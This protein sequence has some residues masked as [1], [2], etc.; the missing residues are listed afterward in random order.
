M[1]KTLIF[2]ILFTVGLMAYGQNI[3]YVNENAAGNGSGDSWANAYTDLADALKAAKDNETQWSSDNPLQIWIAEGTYKPK[4]HPTTFEVNATDRNNTFLL[5][6][7]VNLY[8]GFDGT[9]TSLAERNWNSHKTILSGDIGAV[10]NEADNCYHVLISTSTTDATIIDGLYVTGGIGDVETSFDLDGKSIVNNHGAGFLCLAPITINNCDF[11]SNAVTGSEADGGGVCLVEGPVNMTNCRFRGNAAQD[12]GGGFYLMKDV[13][14]YA[15]NCLFSGNKAEDHGGAI[16]NDGNGTFINCT[17]AENKAKDGGIMDVVFTKPILTN[18]IGIGNSDGIVGDLSADVTYSLMQGFAANADNHNIDASGVS[19][20]DIFVNPIGDLNSV[21]SVEGDYHSLEGSVVI[22]AG[23]NSAYDEAKGG[24]VDMENHLRILNSTIDLGVYELGMSASASGVLYVSNN[25]SGEQTGESW[26]NALA[27]VSDALKYAY[28][29]ASLYSADNPLQIWVAEGTYMPEYNPNNFAK[30]AGDRDNA[31]RLVSNVHIYGGFAGTETE[32][33][34]RDWIA[35]K[36]ILSGD[37]GVRGNA[38]D[39]CYHVL[40][41]HNVTNCVFNGLVL[42]DGQADGS[43]GFSIDAKYYQRDKGGLMFIRENTLEFVNCVIKNNFSKAG[44]GA[45]SGEGYDITAVNSLFYE[46]VV[47]SGHGGVIDNTAGNF[48]A[49]NCTFSKNSADA[50]AAIKNAMAANSYLTNCIVLGNNNGI[51]NVGGNSS[52]SYSLVQGLSSTENGNIDATGVVPTDVFVDY[53]AYDFSLKKTSGLIN[54]GSSAAY[55]TDTYGD[56]DLTGAS[57]VYFYDID[58][59]AYECQDMV[60]IPSADNVLFVKENGTGNGSSWDKAADLAD[61]LKYAHEFSASWTSAEPLN[62]WVAEGKYVPKY[63]PE[64]FEMNASNRDNSF[65]LVSN[66]HIF[67]GF[68]GTETSVAERNWNSYKTVLSGDIGA[69]GDRSDNCYHVLVGIKA[70]NVIFNGLTFSDGQ[71]NGGGSCAIGGEDAERYKGGFIENIRSTFSLINCIVK[72]NKSSADAGAIHNVYGDITAVN[73]LF[74]GNEVLAG[75]NDGGAIDNVGDLDMINCTFVNNKAAQ[76]GSAIKNFNASSCN[77]TNCI[78]IGNKDGIANNNSSPNIRYSLVQGLTST[79]NGNIDASG[80][81]P[82][83]VFADYAAN[84]FSLATGWAGINVG[85]VS[86]YNSSAYGNFDLSCNTR[87]YDGGIDLGAYEVQH[88]GIEITGNILY[89]DAA[90]TGNG[91]GNSWENACTSLAYALKQVYLHRNDWNAT[92][93]LQIWVA[94]GTYKPEY[95]LR[96]ENVFVNAGRENV[97]VLVDNVNLYG[98][99]AGTE[100][101]VE[102][103]D[104]TANKT[105]LSGNVGLA[106]EETDNCYHVAVASGVAH[107]IVVD[108]FTFSHGKADF[109]EVYSIN[110]NEVKGNAGAGLYVVDSKLS[111]RNCV[112]EDNHASLGG[113]VY[114]T[115]SSLTVANGIFKANSSTFNGGTFYN[116]SAFLFIYNTLLA[117]NAIDNNFNAQGAGIYNELSTKS[118]VVVTNCTFVGNEGYTNGCDIYNGAERPV[119]VGNTIA[120]TNDDQI[121]AFSGNVSV[122]YSLVQ[123]LEADD[124]NHN[125]DGTNLIVDS[126]FADYGMEDYTLNVNGLAVNSGSNNLFTATNGENKDLLANTRISGCAI[127]LGAYEYQ[128]D[129]GGLFISREFQNASVEANN[130]S[131]EVTVV[132]GSGNFSYIWSPKPSESNGIDNLD[133]GTYTCLIRDNEYGCVD[134][135]V[136]VIEK[137]GDNAT[138]LHF[139]GDDDHIDLGTS[140][141]KI[142]YDNNRVTVEA[143]VKPTTS[144]GRFGVIAGNYFTAGIQEV[145]FCLRRENSDY[146]FFNSLNESVRINN[147]VKLNEWQHVVGVFDGDN[148]L[149]YVD[150]ESATKSAANKQLNRVPN[151]PIWIGGNSLNFGEVSGAEMFQ[152]WID[153]VRI[154]KTARTEAE[155]NAN[156]DIDLV[157]PTLQ[158]DLL[159]YYKFNQG[160]AN[161]DNP[162]ENVLIDFSQN[163]IRGSLNNFSLSGEESNWTNNSIFIEVSTEIADVQCAGGS[164]GQ[165]HATITGGRAPYTCSWTNSVSTE[166]DLTDLPANDYVLTVTDA[167]NKTLSKTIHVN[168]GSSVVPAPILQDTLVNYTYGDEDVSALEAVVAEG[169]SLNWYPV[170]VGGEKLDFTPVPS[171]DEAGETKYYVAHQNICGESERKSIR[172]VVAKKPLTVRPMA[173]EKIYGEANPAFDYVL[174]DTLIEGD[175]IRGSLS[176]PDNLGVG[177]YAIEQGSL[178]AGDNYDIVLLPDSLTVLPKLIN[179]YV[180]DTS[181]VY[182][183]PDPEFNF[184]TDVDLFDGDA[185]TGKLERLPASKDVGEYSIIGGSLSAGKNYALNVHK[186][187]FTVTRK[188]LVVTPTA[189]QSKIYGD[190]EPVLAYEIPEDLVAGDSL[191][192][193]LT[194]AEGVD[195]GQYSIFKGS[196]SAGDNYNLRIKSAIFEIKPKDITVTAD[197]VNWY[198]GDDYAALTYTVTP[199]LVGDD[200][201]EGELILESTANGNVYNIAQGTLDGGDNYNMNFVGA[202]YKIKYHTHYE[203]NPNFYGGNMTIVAR[204]ESPTGDVMEPCELGAFVA[205]ECRGAERTTDDGLIFLTVAGEDNIS[206]YISFKVYNTE[207]EE[208]I[209]ILPVEAKYSNDAIL[210]SVEDPFIITYRVYSDENDIIDFQ[211]PDMIGSALIDAEEHSVLAKLEVG[212]SLTNLKPLFTVS[213]SAVIADTSAARDFTN[214]QTYNVTA[215]NGDVQAWTVTVVNATPDLQ[216]DENDIVSIEVFNMLGTPSIDAENHTVEVLVFNG[217]DVTSLKPV[218]GISPFATIADTSAARDFT[219]PQIYVVT[220]EN[221]TEQPWTV[222]IEASNE[223]NE[224]EANDILGISVLGQ[225][226]EANIYPSQ[227]FISVTVS[228]GTDITNV[229][230]LF[231]ISPLATIADTTYARDFTKPQIYVV[232]SEVGVSQD[233]VVMVLE[234]TVDVDEVNDN[235]DV[236][237]YPNPVSFGRATVEVPEDCR[238][239]VYNELGQLTQTADLSA[240]SSKVEFSAKGILLLKFKGNNFEATRKILVR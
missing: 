224:H 19:V 227:H 217:T 184:T 172:V 65:R 188:R 219:E 114:N 232:T 63:H 127:D 201:L 113:A 92:N 168:D 222:S 109:T 173:A 154:W 110:S 124:E 136:F 237:I 48:T 95:A 134:E 235:E 165:I 64:T 191:V 209:E 157:E 190:D 162:E 9:E 212:V 33:T 3:Y 205:G 199:P 138:C 40:L 129:F 204:V 72:D 169:G 67:G 175:S 155:I 144:E 79:E 116:A 106:E 22:D 233:W 156:K 68:A 189:N 198:Y 229:R 7:N 202:L 101:S 86:A 240:G 39:N 85:L 214:P 153:E 32:L 94:A 100:S 36:T 193:S 62:I 197:S 37:I 213:D 142:L 177:R 115:L 34:E 30:V 24:K 174:Q 141:N 133:E 42:S 183:S 44:G 31:F 51:E 164:D 223:I 119:V 27:Q 90:A 10:G 70:N 60:L 41:P 50:G 46:N 215:E 75:G 96:G 158:D 132:G 108:G 143:W 122:E 82:T 35:H 131:A 185:F 206:D 25:G 125:L 160:Y 149:L 239:F 17:F 91:L 207:T 29:N 52:V 11:Y 221:G 14:L 139:D 5:V 88:S 148:L 128:Q 2:A 38:S 178:S 152:G 166:T 112:F 66:V 208:E 83:D 120:I 55:N 12:D 230:P 180:E 123:G 167:D 80:V 21:P 234:S 61:A 121:S 107:D 76:S 196:L 93:P 186:G 146:V 210:G 118:D 47:E 59:G 23:N 13:D 73:T 56:K 220:A 238:M 194:R 170:A 104:L 43:G 137:D 87:V 225:V 78:I 103:R 195:V 126:L 26:D 54:R 1:K 4:Y 228:K 99:F 226:G 145:Q 8:G 89:V 71:A 171:T 53:A 105:V 147:S 28:E 6:N 236:S 181:V 77:I 163:Q 182:G 200:V 211:L 150:D 159:A 187:T 15:Y 81:V 176:C 192:G 74:V 69:R 179:I 161:E 102:E 140:L 97:F 111:L 98:G 57:R 84:D 20:N 130:G 18:C 117:G 58:M 216:S 49:I 135:E 218:F 151:S 203:P 45:V 231:T 16:S